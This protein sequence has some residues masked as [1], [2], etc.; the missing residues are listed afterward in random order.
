MFAHGLSA[1]VNQL[2][3]IWSA[4]ATPARSDPLSTLASAAAVSGRPVNAIIQPSHGYSTLASHQSADM[5]ALGM[6]YASASV[7][8]MQPM[9]PEE[10]KR[11]CMDDYHSSLPPH[12]P[13]HAHR[14]DTLGH[15]T[16]PTLP[17]LSSFP[18]SRPS[19][20][21]HFPPLFNAP[22]SETRSHSYSA[23]NAEPGSTASSPHH[24]RISDLLSPVRSDS[25]TAAAAL[26]LDTSNDLDSESDRRWSAGEISVI[27][28]SLFPSPILKIS[29]W[30]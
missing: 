28:L 3:R 12:G 5:Q 25:F 30:C 19:S 18:S 4:V 27:D 26:V 9:W 17:P 24:L 16:T 29:A 15:F 7:A 14:S 11:K 2:R 22:V 8:P 13:P 1:E 10:K 20:A 21:P 6:G 23:D